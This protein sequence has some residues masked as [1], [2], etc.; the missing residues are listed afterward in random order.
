MEG[1]GAPTVGGSSRHNPA[2]EK[3]LPLPLLGQERG[4]RGLESGSQRSQEAGEPDRFQL[5]RCRCPERGTERVSWMARPFRRQI[6][7]PRVRWPPKGFRS[8]RCT[9]VFEAHQEKRLCSDDAFESHKSPETREALWSASRMGQPS[10][11]ALARGGHSACRGHG[12]TDG[13]GAAEPHAQVRQPFPSR[14]EVT[15]GGPAEAGLAPREPWGEAA[16]GNERPGATGGK[17]AAA[18]GVQRRAERPEEGKTRRNRRSS[19]RPVGQVPSRWDAR[20]PA[21]PS[22]R[23]GRDHQAAQL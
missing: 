8:D 10:K 18:L 4:R 19:W 5:L 1:C 6:R 15:C 12:R 7:N 11:V 14:L 23:T 20:C 13:G 3:P 17:Q 9:S 2:P 21:A 16:G 22:L